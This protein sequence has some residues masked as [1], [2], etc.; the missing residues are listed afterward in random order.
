M[1]QLSKVKEFKY[2]DHDVKIM[3]KAPYIVGDLELIPSFFCFIIDGVDQTI[4]GLATAE[5]AEMD[6]QRTVDEWLD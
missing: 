5:A 3:K 2:K 1:S 6:A 4:K